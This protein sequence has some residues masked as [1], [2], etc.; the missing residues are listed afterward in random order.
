MA[1]IPATVS[2]TLSYPV[3]CLC[4]GG[5]GGGGGFFGLGDVER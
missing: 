1:W 2:T 3:L 4:G 5:G